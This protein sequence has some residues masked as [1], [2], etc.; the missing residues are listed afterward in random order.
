[1]AFKKRRAA[2]ARP[3]RKTPLRKRVA[4]KRSAPQTIRIVLEQPN[5]QASLPLA[6]PAQVGA[7]QAMSP[8][9]SRF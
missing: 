6:L 4:T 2:K 9:K 1:M 8:R 5:P 3:R 7:V